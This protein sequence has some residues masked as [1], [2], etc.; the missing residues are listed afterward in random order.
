M[1]LQVPIAFIIFNRPDLTEIL[2]NQIVK[3]KPKELLI[4]EDGP[5][6]DDDKIKCG[7]KIV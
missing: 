4:I 3:V 7:T 5:K 2:F 6:D 1:I